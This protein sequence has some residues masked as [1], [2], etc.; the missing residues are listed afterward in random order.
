MVNLLKFHIKWWSEQQACSVVELLTRD[1]GVAGLS[2]TW[3][4]NVS[5]CV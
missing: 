3:A 1:R 5:F 2:I 4:I